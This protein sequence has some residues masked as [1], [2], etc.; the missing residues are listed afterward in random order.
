M[1]L[2]GYAVKASGEEQPSEDDRDRFMYKGKEI[3]IERE[4]AVDGADAKS[5]RSTHKPSQLYIDGERILTVHDAGEYRAANFMFS[6]QPT[7]EDLAKKMVDYQ[8]A[9]T[10]R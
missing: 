9:L 6:P 4:G 10:R 5:A 1:A 7:L 2:G 3:R 8:V